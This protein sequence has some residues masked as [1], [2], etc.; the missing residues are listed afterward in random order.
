MACGTGPVTRTV[1]SLVMTATEQTAVATALLFATMAGPVG[2]QT[3]EGPGARAQGMSAFVAVAD[4]AS[5]VYWNPAGLASGAYFSLVLDR[6]EGEALPAGA[7]RG[8]KRSS[9]LLAL[10]APALGLSYY[11]LRS[12]N[13]EPASADLPG[14]SR[15]QTLVTHHAGATLV[16]SIFDRLAVGAT[17]K[18]VRGVATSASTRGEVE[19]LLDDPEMGVASNRFDVDV[20]VMATARLIRAGLTVRNI[21][22]PEFESLDGDMLRLDRQARAGIS[23]LL[24]DRWTAAADFDLT[25]NR[26]PLGDVRSLAFGTEGRLTRR[27]VARAGVQLNLAGDL[28]RTPVGTLGASY[29]VFGSML[30]DAHVSTGSDEAFTGWGVAGRVVF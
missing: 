6:T 12:S 2:A 15:V 25:R 19:E 1:S 9:W 28:G 18:L 26:G 24:T 20:G 23:L 21:V 11:R 14:F 16:Q 10:S 17:L 22:Q 3:F 27:A 4:D 7:G 30:V 8:G 5:A 13:V 29:A